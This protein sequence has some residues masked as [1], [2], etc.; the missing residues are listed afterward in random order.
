MFLKMYA[1]PFAQGKAQFHFAFPENIG[2][3]GGKQFIKQHTANKEF[4]FYFI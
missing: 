3:G 2:G 4:Y 1:L